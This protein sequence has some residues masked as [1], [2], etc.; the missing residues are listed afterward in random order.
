VAT[1]SPAIS[2]TATTLEYATYRFNRRGAVV[3]VSERVAEDIVRYYH[4][5]APIHVIHH[6]VDLQ[7]FS[8]DSR[9]RWRPDA[10]AQ[11]GFSGNEMVFLYVGD[12]R[13]GAGRCIQALSE[14]EEGRLLF[15]SRTPAGPYQRMA[16]KA[17]LDSRVTFLGPTNKVERTYAAADALLLPTPYDAFAMVVSEAMAC[18]LPVVVSR[19]AGVSELIR[20]GVNG[21]LLDDAASVV[22]LASHMR[23]LLRDRHYATRLGCN[24]R[25]SVEPMSWDAVAAQ[26]M[27]VYQDLVRKAN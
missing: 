5:E 8:P 6:G 9:R 4:C 16:E 14:L 20:H 21:L 17:G 2:A 11:H 10:R 13:K 7:L 19:E 27:Q 15:V 22:E 18:G 3:A 24:A 26:T 1:S 23:S 25:N 12:L